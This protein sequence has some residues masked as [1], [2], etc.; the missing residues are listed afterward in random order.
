MQE[1]YMDTKIL[2]NLTGP[3]SLSSGKNPPPIINAMANIITCLISIF[4]NQR[5]FGP[6]MVVKGEPDH[7][8]TSL[9]PH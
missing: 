5:V 8:S 2:S 6:F 9:G 7:L 4:F 1:T 3:L